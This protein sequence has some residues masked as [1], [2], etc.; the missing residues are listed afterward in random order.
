MFELYNSF[1]PLLKFFWGVAVF[2]GLIFIV[3]TIMT[4][5]GFADTDVDLD[6]DTADAVETDFDAGGAFELFTFRN[7]VN[8]LLGFGWGG[9]SFY[10]M[11]SNKI[12]L[13]SLAFLIGAFFIFLFFVI[14]KQV[15]K[16]SENNS[17]DIQEAIGKTANV[18]LFIPP[19]KEGDGIVHVSIKGALRELK[20]QTL[21][22]EKIETGSEVRI[23]D[24]YDNKLIVA[25]V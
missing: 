4:F 17:F 12:L 15:L 10:N 25:K 14:M 16:L 23:I 22:T 1:E 21:D 9:I 19:N 13:L 18:Y 6:F 8:F 24:I 11:I 3:Q 2:S 7:L 5:I 20:A